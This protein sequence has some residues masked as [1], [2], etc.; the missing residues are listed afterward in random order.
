[1]SLK[2]GVCVLVASAGYHWGLLVRLVVLQVD[3][4]LAGP[5]AEEERRWQVLV[6]EALAME[7][8]L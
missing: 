8:R 4:R 3:A 5:L 2:L 1:M 7:Q 6:V